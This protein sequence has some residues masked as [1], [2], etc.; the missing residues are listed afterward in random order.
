MSAKQA[1][2]LI[3][4]LGI[5]V[6]DESLY[7]RKLTRMMLM[8]IGAKTIFEASDGV[9][10]LDAIRSAN[11]DVA[12]I[13][14]DLPVLSGSQVIKIVRSPDVFPKPHLPIV[15]LTAHA[16]RA[17]VAEAMRLGVHEFLLKPTSPQALRDRLLSII[18][19]PRP[20]VQVGK[21]YVPEPRDGRAES[22]HP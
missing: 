21:L 6:V 13:D 8:N 17:N 14:W 16:N 7:M 1:E 11:P 18:V 20:M 5:L 15:M 10:A 9:A 19:K 2:K 22:R 12:F 4:N 3:E